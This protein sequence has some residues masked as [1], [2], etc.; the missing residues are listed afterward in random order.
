MEI[1]WGLLTLLASLVGAAFAFHRVYMFFGKGGMSSR[2]SHV[3]LSDS[4]IYLVTMM[5][6]VMT[7][8][9]Q[10]ADHVLY[11]AR[12]FFICFNILCGYRLTRPIK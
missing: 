9:G 10:N 11:P 7:Y 1:D 8:V 4:L 2:L 5:F 6:G 3:F 12:F